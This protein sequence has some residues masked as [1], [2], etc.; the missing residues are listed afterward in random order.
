MTAVIEPRHAAAVRLADLRTAT[1]DRL[2]APQRPRHWYVMP[3]LPRTGAG[4]VARG[5]VAEAVRAGTLD[6]RRLR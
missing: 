6:A 5:T 3:S 1:R 2:A 4:K